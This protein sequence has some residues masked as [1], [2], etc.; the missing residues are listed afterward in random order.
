[1]GNAFLQMFDMSS[2]DLLEDVLA[3]TATICIVVG[4]DDR[5]VY[6]SPRI[7]ELLG[8]DAGD[9]IGRPLAEMRSPVELI[10]AI[11]NN[12][13]SVIE[14]NK[15]T[16]TRV[17][18]SGV[19]PL[20]TFEVRSVPHV[21]EGRPRSA[22]NFIDEVTGRVDAE[23]THRCIDQIVDELRSSTSI[24]KIIPKVLAQINGAFG[25]DVSAVL[26]RRD[27]S[28]CPKYALGQDLSLISYF[29][30]DEGAALTR[31]VQS[32]NEVHILSE[33]DESGL[34]GVLKE[35][36]DVRTVV[37]VPLRIGSDGRGILVLA[38][39]SL[40]DPLSSSNLRHLRNVGAILSMAFSEDN[41]VLQSKNEAGCINTDV[42]ALEACS[43]LM[44]G[45]GKIKWSSQKY[46]SLV[47]DAFKGANIGSMP[48][49]SICPWFRGTS[50][51][52]ALEQIIASDGP[53]AVGTI[54]RPDE[55]GDFKDWQVIFSPVPNGESVPD[56][57]ILLVN[58]TEWGTVNRKNAR[59]VHA[60]HEEQYRVRT[61]LDSV[62]VGVYISDAEGRILE[63]NGMG[64]R[65]W[66]QSPLPRNIE[67]Y[68][69][70]NATWPA[71]GERLSTDDWPLAKAVRRGETTIGEV[72]DFR[73]FDGREGTI[74]NSA[75]PI[76]NCNGQIIGAVEIDQDITEMKMLERKLEAI[77]ANLEAIIH[78]MPAGV[79][80]A[81]GPHGRITNCNNELKRMLPQNGEIPSCVEGYSRWG[82]L[83]PDNLAPLRSEDYPL[84]IALRE[85]RTVSNHQSVVRKGNGDLI[86]ILTSASPVIG[87][88]G[89]II[90]AVAI[91][92][93]ITHQKEIENRLE[94]QTRDLAQFNADLQRF[95]YVTSN[96]LR[97]SLKSINN[98]LNLIE[99][100]SS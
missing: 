70:Y 68:V 14:N 47:P 60:I 19:R 96:E 97:E 58:V 89:D 49:A 16:A 12:A 65:I 79:A 28:W 18:V 45:R 72:I 75:A 90:G 3:H 13:H 33:G 40:I 71:T 80:I 17:S 27:G 69:D 43:A 46:T 74:I 78:Q 64:S 63:I 10:E 92:T 84:A 61:L 6:A 11:G 37:A 30:L 35:E 91:F 22:M 41:D 15:A 48:Q 82:L 51:E 52:M 20:R 7:T 57:L 9:L 77:K 95:A 2:L 50:P 36:W 83:D 8:H 42:S 98:Y 59:L 66:G 93:D 55:N 39:R 85:R 99:K 25:P 81:E 87:T 31:L 24:D 100:N 34:F 4:A 62:P 76:R 56:V 26:T 29:R 94:K 38:Y 23:R 21:E 53:M 44:D 67:E 88:E 54:H 73:S 5:I 86:T 32:V 1:M